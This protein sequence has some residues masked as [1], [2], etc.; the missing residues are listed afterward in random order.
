MVDR[1]D[2][3]AGDFD[4]YFNYNL[5]QWE[6]GTASGSSGEGCGGTSAHVG[7]TNGAGSY[8]EFAGSG[9]NGAFIDSGTCGPA[10]AYAL[11]QHMLALGDGQ[12]QLGRYGFQVR[13]GVVETPVPEPATMVLVGSGLAAIVR[14]A[15]RKARS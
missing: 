3:A 9:V 14:G 11:T 6:A 12:D 4:F 8:N 2:I 13:S 10:G 5:I 1:S 15:R 7:W